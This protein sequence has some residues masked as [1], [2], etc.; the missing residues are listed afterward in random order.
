MV[1]MP[2]RAERVPGGTHGD[3]AKIDSFGINPASILSSDL[4][5]GN[6]IS[7]LDSGKLKEKAKVTEL[8]C[9]MAKAS[10]SA[11]GV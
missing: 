11:R 10:Q 6:L 5:L 7:L 8:V 3:R 2:R 4:L 1:R 9:T